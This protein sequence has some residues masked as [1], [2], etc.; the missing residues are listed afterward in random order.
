MN[1]CLL[2]Y[3]QG[4]KPDFPPSKVKSGCGEQCIWVLDC[5]SEYILQLQRFTWK[6]WV[7]SICH[8]QNR[9]IGRFVTMLP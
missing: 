6:L 4:Y 7:S 9:T 1:K 2:P 3:A 8:S 5:L